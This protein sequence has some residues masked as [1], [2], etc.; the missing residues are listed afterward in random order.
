M[1]EQPRQ[2]T[3]RTPPADRPLSAAGGVTVAEAAARLGVTPDAVRRRL[4]RGTL[5]GDKT[6]EGQWRVWLPEP[7][8]ED[9]SGDREEAAR[10]SPGP[11]TTPPGRS[12][13]DTELI[14]ALQATVTDLRTRLDAEGEARRRADHI[15]L[16]V[17]R[18]LPEL[19]TGQDAP[20]DANTGP[21]SGTVAAEA[22]DTR[23]R[24]WRRWWQRMTGG[25]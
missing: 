2:D 21:Q 24:A 9:D 3:A 22:L 17:S 13:A 23:Q 14:E 20:Q 19:G 8:P 11:D 18:R 1:S 15:I 10:P 5:A 4:H 25:G 16:E 12:P 7:P 6:E